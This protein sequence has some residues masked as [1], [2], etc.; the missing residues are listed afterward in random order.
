MDLPYKLIRFAG[1]GR[2]GMQP[3][4]FR[5]I[6]PALPEPGKYEGSSHQALSSTREIR[7]PES[8]SVVFEG[9][10]ERWRRID[11][12]DPRIDRLVRDLGI[13]GPELADS[14]LECLDTFRL[15]VVDFREDSRTAAAL[16]T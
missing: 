7:L 3:F 10:A 9:L 2:T 8:D 16:Q 11:R 5:V 15:A 6:F 1:D 12:C 14:G 13:F 4:S